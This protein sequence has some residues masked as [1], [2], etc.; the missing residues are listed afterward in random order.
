MFILR[1][2]NAKNDMVIKVF[3]LNMFMILQKAIRCQQFL[4]SELLHRFHQSAFLLWDN[5]LLFIEWH[6][7]V[8]LKVP[9]PLPYEQICRCFQSLNFSTIMCKCWICLSQKQRC[10][11]E[12][13]LTTLVLFMNM[14][15]QSKPPTFFTILLFVA[16]FRD[17]VRDFTIV[18]KCPWMGHIVIDNFWQTYSPYLFLLPDVLW[19]ENMILW[20]SPVSLYGLTNIM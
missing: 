20:I 5:T 16:F 18:I 15:N 11:Q 8:V 19:A 14:L 9:W 12:L 7:H 10:G 2:W 4:P 1:I 6:I 13:A 3:K 17:F